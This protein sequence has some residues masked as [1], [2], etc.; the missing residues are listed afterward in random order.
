MAAMGRGDPVLVLKMHHDARAGGLLTCIEVNEP[1]NVALG[2]VRVQPFLEL[3]DRPH[4][5]IGLQQALLV[6]RENPGCAVWSSHQ[7][8]P[9]VFRR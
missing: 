8:P 6:Q 9:F 2:E 7:C 1:R 5:S 3:A 4:G